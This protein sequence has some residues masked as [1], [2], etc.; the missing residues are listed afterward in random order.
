MLRERALQ[1]PCGIPYWM[2][3]IFSLI[4]GASVTWYADPADGQRVRLIHVH[5]GQPISSCDAR[6]VVWQRTQ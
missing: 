6:Y 5:P 4:S 2:N 3:A 1:N